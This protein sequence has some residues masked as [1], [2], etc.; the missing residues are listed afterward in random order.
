MKT[1][2]ENSFVHCVDKL[3]IMKKLLL[4]LLFIPLVS[5][6]QN[7]I[8]DNIDHFKELITEPMY[9]G[10]P[11]SFFKGYWI[12]TI[13]IIKMAENILGMSVFNSGPHTK[14][15]FCSDCNSVEGEFG[16]YNPIFL[17]ELIKTIK[18]MSP[19]LK[20]TLK[21]LYFRKFETPLK[22][23]MEN[24][25]EDHFTSDCNRW[26]LERIKNKDDIKEILHEIFFG[27]ENNC[28]EISGETLFWIRRDY[29]GTSKQF[30]ELFNLIMKEF[31]PEGFSASSKLNFN[32][33]IGQSPYTSYYEN[34]KLKVAGESFEEII[35][36]KVSAKSGLNVRMSPNLKSKT[37]GKLLYGIPVTVESKTGIKLTV[38][39]T[40][41]ETGIKSEIK[42]EWIEVTG[43]IVTEYDNKNI[44]HKS[45][46]SKL[47]YKRDGDEVTEGEYMQLS[48]IQKD[49]LQNVIFQNP[50][51]RIKVR[52]YVFDGFLE[53]HSQ[54]IRKGVWTYYSE[55]G[56][57]T[58]DEFYVVE[59]FDNPVDGKGERMVITPEE[60][61]LLSMGSV[62]RLNGKIKK[63]E[64]DVDGNIT[65]IVEQE[66]ELDDG[67]WGPAK[68]SNTFHKNGKI[69]CVNESSSGTAISYCLDENGKLLGLNNNGLVFMRDQRSILSKDIR[70]F[71]LTRRGLQ[72]NRI[73]QDQ[74]P[75]LKQTK[76][77]NGRWI[78]TVDSLSGIEIKNGKWIVFYKSGEN[79]SSLIYDFKILEDYLTITND[80]DTLEY[81][82]IEYSKELLSLSYVGRGN[83]LNYKPER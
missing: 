58:K 47:L 32:T 66:I 72:K 1:S 50:L 2:F 16:H 65:E 80:S 37:I 83:T 78:S 7:T 55:S 60:I 62:I 4:V 48:D 56:D 74:K 31:D 13:D 23:L 14:E 24:Q 27:I 40:D 42:G 61:H 57:I 10:S 19:E 21:P 36:S 38:I 69:K 22:K 41:R 49:S 33:S 79:E 73:E 71:N 30:L 11:K 8:E 81:Y 25:I 28:D 64:Y 43:Y 18:S 39:D 5:F 51:T 63:I 6:G 15:W 29:D 67:L 3:D 70:D 68:I 26:L 17:V 53:K 59:E 44:E 75:I 35:G 54:S 77:K 52:G 46:N 34:G 82:I 45:A 20:T 12:A 9:G 76:F